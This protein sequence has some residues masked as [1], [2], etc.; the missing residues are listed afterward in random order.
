MID[1]GCRGVTR[2]IAGGD[3]GGNFPHEALRVISQGKWGYLH[4]PATIRAS[5]RG[6]ES[7]IT[8]DD[9]DFV[10]DVSVC[11]SAG[12]RLLNHR[13]VQIHDVMVCDRTDRNRHALRR[14]GVDDD[15]VRLRVAAHV[16]CAVLGFRNQRMLTIS[17][18]LGSRHFERPGAIVAG[19][20][21]GAQ[22]IRALID[23]DDVALRGATAMNHRRGVVGLALGKDG[24]Q[25]QRVVVILDRSYG[26]CCRRYEVHC[27]VEAVGVADVAR[28]VDRLCREGVG[29]HGVADQA[30]GS[31]RLDRPGV[32]RR[33][34]GRADFSARA[35]AMH[36]VQVNGGTHLA[37]AMED[38]VRIVGE[39]AI[40]QLAGDRTYSVIGVID[41]RFDRRGQVNV[42]AVV[43]DFRTPVA[44][45]V[46]RA[47]GQRVVTFR[48]RRGV[49]RP[50]ARRIGRGGADQGI[51]VVVYLDEAASLGPALDLRSGIVGVAATVDQ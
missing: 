47:H 11:G 38:R 8:N 4:T 23:V 49:Q 34:R 15:W 1:R 33:D 22:Y 18:S 31:G 7:C 16:A 13:C 39:G 19:N 25:V 24:D 6:G 46:F 5:H 2:S 41:G 12:D 42:E 40:V 43:R 48:Q 9:R 50:L 10:A 45:R 26:R 27:Q 21:D 32:V 17:Q 37:R 29:R 20:R 36:F 3:A 28:L 51:G 14:D 35:V 30:V 44:R